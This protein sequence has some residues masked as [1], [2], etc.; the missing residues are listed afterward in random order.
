LL[1][2]IVY[3]VAIAGGLMA[4]TGARVVDAETEESAGAIP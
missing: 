3:I 1:G 2:V 4:L